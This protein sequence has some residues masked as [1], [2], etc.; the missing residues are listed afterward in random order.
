MDRTSPLHGR[1]ATSSLSADASSDALGWVEEHGDFLYRFASARV[2][3]ATV[4]EDLVQETFLA[5]LQG[6]RHQEGPEAERRWMIGIMKHK[7]VDHFRR[8]AREPHVPSD[9]QAGRAHDNDFLSDGHWRPEMAAIHSWPEKPDGLL[10]QRQFRQVLTACLDRLPPKAAQ[11][12][13]L[14]ELDEIDAEEV[15]R[16]L[17]LTRTNLDVILHR[18]RKQLRNCLATRYFGW[19]QEA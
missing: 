8:A 2:R 6:A 12:F 19:R 9:N 14:R 15:C 18:A 16:L 7:I 5:A 1:T 17:R 11:V 3:D 4:A 10:E 13:T